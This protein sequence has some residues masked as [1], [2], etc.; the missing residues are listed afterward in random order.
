MQKLPISVR[1]QNCAASAHNLFSTFLLDQIELLLLLLLLLFF[2]Q[3]RQATKTDRP[4]LFDAD[5][6]RDDDSVAI[7]IMRFGSSIFK[8]FTAL[9][10]PLRVTRPSVFVCE[11]DRELIGAG[12]QSA[13]L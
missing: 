7:I 4:G 8:P 1:I 11:C 9:V 6:S 5:E 13:A 3:R 10:G 12:R 2:A